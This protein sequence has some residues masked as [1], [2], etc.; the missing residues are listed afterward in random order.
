MRLK[1]AAS[2]IVRRN[3]TEGETSPLASRIAGGRRGRSEMRTSPESKLLRY[4][5]VG[6]LGSVE[7]IRS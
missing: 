5:K 3:R 4:G 7:K 2:T 1:W 6:P